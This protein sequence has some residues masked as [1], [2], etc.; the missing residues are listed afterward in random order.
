MENEVPERKEEE[1][2]QETQAPVAEAAPVSEPAPAPAPT[3]EP[4]P[5]PAPAPEPEPVPAPEPGLTNEQ[6]TFALCGY[7]VPVV[8]STSFIAP[9]II[10]LLKKGED[11]YIEQHAKQA[12]NFQITIMIAAFVAW[13]G[14]FVLIGFIL[15]PV[16]VIAYLVFSII[17]GVK[18]YKGEDYKIPVC[19]RFI[20]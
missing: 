14:L 20:K 6:K 10:W 18:A 8:T 7:L 13:L 12:L 19:I 1:Q 9:L 16:V 5:A 3:P 4:E 11:S 2:V 15:L 17:A